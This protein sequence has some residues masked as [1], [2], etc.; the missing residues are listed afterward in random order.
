MT[1]GLHPLDRPIWNALHTRQAPLALGGPLAMKFV[2]EIAAFA[3]TQDDGDAS[4]AALADLIPEDGAVYLVR[5]DEHPLPTGTYAEK[6]AIAVQMIAE[7]FVATPHPEGIAPLGP[8]DVPEMMA[9][10][11]LTEPG[12]FF[13]RTHE[14]GQFWGVRENGRLAAMAG[15]RLKLP[16]L[17]ELSGVCT[18]PDFRGRGYAALLS[19]AVCSLIVAHGEIPFLHCYA[20]NAG[21]IALYERLGFRIRARMNITVLRHA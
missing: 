16:G 11:A 7:S 5:A 21:A 6:T 8:A 14:L 20:D 15:E 19:K 18:H 10:T 3:D 13:T 17:T 12:P 9:L 4:L 1:E 2:P